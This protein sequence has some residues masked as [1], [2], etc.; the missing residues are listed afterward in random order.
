MPVNSQNTYP[1]VVGT[2]P[3][4][5]QCVKNG[6]EMLALVRDF[7]S[8]Q[9]LGGNS[10]SS[11][12]TQDAAGAQALQLAQQIASQIATLQ[13]SL[14]VYR[15]APSYGL[16]PVSSA[17]VE[18]N[19]SW[20]NPLPSTNYDLFI[21][22]VGN[23]AAASLSANFAYWIVQGSQT[24]TSCRIHFDSPPATNKQTQFSWLVALYPEQYSSGLTGTITSFSPV[25]GSV[26]G[27]VSVTI[28]GS[29]FSLATQVLF[30]GTNA[31]SFTVNSDTQ[32][33]AVV[34]PS[35]S[36]GAGVIQVQQANGTILTSSGTFNF[37]T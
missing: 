16:I 13:N 9:G 34:D 30:N 8:V 33:T 18:F 12:P 27:S 32:I 23:S 24:T 26:S 5:R 11:F 28:F 1:I 35:T 2:V 29:G 19:I 14:P 17:A 25:G 3:A 7:G 15:S 21:S 22:I 10:G 37:T 31:T 36:T 6:T 4:D 20:T